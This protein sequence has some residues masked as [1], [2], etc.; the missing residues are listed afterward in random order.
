[1]AGPERGPEPRDINVTY[2]AFAVV[3]TVR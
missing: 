1:V 3:P 2:G